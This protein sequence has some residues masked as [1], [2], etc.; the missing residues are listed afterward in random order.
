MTRKV[1]LSFEVPYEG[2]L[3]NGLGEG[4][5]SF[6]ALPGSIF[7]RFRCFSTVMGQDTNT[8]MRTPVM[9]KGALADK[10]VVCIGAGG[11]HVLAATEN[12]GE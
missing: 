6:P 9:V 12:I 11:S 2:N 10:K 7:A 1:A 4:W 3:K 8:D 5:K